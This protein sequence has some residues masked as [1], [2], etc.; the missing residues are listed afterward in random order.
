MLQ[1]FA[2]TYYLMVYLMA[3]KLYSPVMAGTGLLP[4]VVTVVPVSALTG[5][6]ITK[7]GRYRWAIWLGWSVSVLGLGLLIVLGVGTH[8]A[9]WIFIFICAGA[10]QGLLLNGHATAISA[11]CGSEDAAHAASMYSFMRS[12]GL[13][14][15]VIV[16]GTVFQNF[17]RMRLAHDGLPSISAEFEGFIP[18]LQKMGDEDPMKLALQQAYAWALNMLF[19]TSTGIGSIG[20]LLSLT[21]GD[22]PL[23]TAFRPQHRLRR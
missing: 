20:L 15:G 14:L 10:P 2:M 5:P 23:N 16:G 9:I 6:A 11:S 1:M 7:L 4:F 19:A 13:C 17:L 3:C 12:F 18:I 8:P 22:Y 21:T